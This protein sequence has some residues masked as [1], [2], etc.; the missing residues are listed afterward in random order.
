MNCFALFFNILGFLLQLHEKCVPWNAARCSVFFSR[1]ISN[2]I[3]TLTSLWRFIIQKAAEMLWSGSWAQRSR[4]LNSGG[5]KKRGRKMYETEW[6]LIFG[7]M[8]H[9]HIGFKSVYEW[10]LS[11]ILFHVTSEEDYKQSWRASV[12]VSFF[13][14]VKR[15]KTKLCL[16]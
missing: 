1:S 12:S 6:D 15:S 2:I 9:I 8:M 11:K 4:R 14:A 13:W 5:E 10:V 7:R 3:V 16:P